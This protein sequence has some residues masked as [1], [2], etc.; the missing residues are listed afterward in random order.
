MAAQSL[1]EFYNSFNNKNTVRIYQSVI[2][3]FERSLPE[4]LE[5]WLNRSS[6]EEVEQHLKIYFNTSIKNRLPKTR[7]LQLAAIRQLLLHFRKDPTFLKTLAGRN[8]GYF[9]ITMDKIPPNGLLCEMLK[10]WGNPWRAFFS[11]LATSGARKGELIN[12]PKVDVDL[13]AKPAR[14]ILRST[15]GGAPRVVFISTKAAALL[16]E[17]IKS[18]PG[19]DRIF[20]FSPR[21]AERAWV[22]SIKRLGQAERDP[23]SHRFVYHPHTLRKRFRT[24]TGAILPRDVIEALMGHEGYL[25]GSYRR[26]ETEELAAWYLKAEGVLDLCPS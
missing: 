20:C 5:P 1:E 25:D 7:A 14:I 24:A 12:V 18:T 4:P 19:L 9:A 23:G 2:R 13:Q 11:C 26:Y 3:S 6:Q 8:P 15:K 17:H 16:G 22:R 21:D 10:I